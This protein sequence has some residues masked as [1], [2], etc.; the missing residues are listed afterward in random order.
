V[1]AA[2][3]IRERQALLVINGSK[4]CV[5]GIVNWH[6]CTYESGAYITILEFKGVTNTVR[7][8][9]R[10]QILK[11]LRSGESMLLLKTDAEARRHGYR[12]GLETPVVYA[13]ND[14]CYCVNLQD[15]SL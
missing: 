15:F 13:E 6:T 5:G 4:G 14:V 9:D 12:T 1:P 10:T 2:A 3:A 7:V 11:G 8:G